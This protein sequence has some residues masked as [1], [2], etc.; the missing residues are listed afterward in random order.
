[1]FHDCILLLFDFHV[2]LNWYS[3]ANDTKFSRISDA[4]IFHHP[5]KNERYDE[6]IIHH[7]LHP[8][9]TLFESLVQSESS[10]SAFSADLTLH[11]MY[12][13]VEVAM[14]VQQGVHVRVEFW[15][16]HLTFLWM[17]HIYYLWLCR[18]YELNINW[19]IIFY[20]YIP[21][22]MARRF[23]AWRRDLGKFR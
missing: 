4:K 15:V 10:S 1:M 12:R 2:Q 5:V 6:K 7:V 21:L 18:I 16:D 3:C 19:I 9:P 20:S 11:P 22:R 14:L 17:F 8:L 13:L 23:S